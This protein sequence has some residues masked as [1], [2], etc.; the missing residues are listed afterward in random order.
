MKA[1]KL[2]IAALA[3][4]MCLSVALSLCACNN[5]ETTQ[6]STTVSKSEDPLWKTATH[7]SDVT[8]GEG[9]T[10]IQVD[11]IAGEKSITATINTDAITLEEALKSAD[12]VE[13]EESEY[14]LFIKKVNGIEADFDKDQT[15]WAVSK[16]GEY[17]NS[18]VS[19][20]TIKSGEHYELKRTK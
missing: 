8:L 5:S 18:G 9:K 7:K 3:L 10:T 17:M 20:I 19:T 16:D 4:V 1:K 12:L 11:I 6:Q 13:G 15:Y 2:L 14:G